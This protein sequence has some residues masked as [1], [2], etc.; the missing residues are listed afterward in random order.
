MSLFD[1]FFSLEALPDSMSEA[2]VVLVLKPGK[3]PEDYSSYRLISLINVEVKIL[4]KILANR[5]RSWRK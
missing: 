3:D 2:V 5:L 4:A 1:R